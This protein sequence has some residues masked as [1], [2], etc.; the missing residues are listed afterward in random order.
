MS[1]DGVELFNLDSHSANILDGQDAADFTVTYYATQADADTA[2]NPLTSPYEN[3][4]N[5]QTIYARVESNVA[6]DCYATAAFD[7]IVNEVPY[8]TFAEDVDYEVCPNATVPIEVSAIAENYSESDVSIVWYQNDT[9]ITGE[10]SLTLPILVEGDYTIEVTFNNTGCIYEATV[11]VIE[12]ETCVIPQGIS[13]DGDGL[14]DSFD[15]SSYDVQT[16]EIY[17]RHGIL[18][19]SKSNYSDEWVGQSDN[20]DKL[21]VG[22]YFY[23]MKYQGSKQKAAWVYL[24]Y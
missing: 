15:L 4:S 5:P 7:L 10:N 11:N 3:T 9:L 19:Y 8:T 6:F 24:N 13:P 18:V 20:G 1:R 16:L 14:N 2:V 12:L 23:V 17:N 22:T 21:P